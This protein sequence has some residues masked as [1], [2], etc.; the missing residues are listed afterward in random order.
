MITNPF[1]PSFGGAPEYFAG[2]TDLIKRVENALSDARSPDR[3][4]F[5]TGCRGSGKTALLERLSHLARGERWL[6]IDVHSS[7]AVLSILDGIGASGVFGRLQVSPSVVLP[8]GVQV[9]GE[10]SS[11]SVQNSQKDFAGELVRACESLQ[12]RRGIFITID[13]VQKIP[14]GDMEEICAAVQMARRKGLP[15]SLMLAGLPGSKELVAGYKGCTFMQ[16]VE[17]VHIGGILI[18]ETTEAFA[19]LLHL[20]PK[21]EVTEDVVWELSSMSQGYPYLI[22]LVGYCFVKSL[23]EAYP[24]G[25]RRPTVEDV[26]FVEDE[27]YGTYGTNVLAPSTRGVRGEAMLYLK[28]M[29]HLQDEDGFVRTADVAKALGK[30]Q[31]QL[32]TCRRSLI[33][34]RLVLPTGYG[35]V[36][37]GL[38]YLTRYVLEAPAQMRFNMEGRWV[39]R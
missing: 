5:V 26:R 24:V 16:R 22:Q 1:T 17:D 6:S 38:P 11:S 20:V 32:S 15:I 34:R 25:V 35:K 13:E 3:A 10:A 2:R 27:V 39:P 30:E 23:D 33:Q 31:R 37:F 29:A 7:H 19:D 18:D 36:C 28:A 12:G 4:M 8:G 14:E 21:L 9:K